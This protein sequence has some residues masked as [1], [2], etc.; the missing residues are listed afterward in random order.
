MVFQ[1]DFFGRNYMKNE[2]LP[3][4]KVGKINILLVDDRKENLLALAAILEAP[5]VNII[6]AE[7][8]NAA[9]GRMLEYDFAV[10]I[11]DVMMPEMNGF[12]VAE[13]MQ[14]NKKTMNT[15][16][17]FVTASRTS[18]QWD[19]IDRGYEVGAVDYLFKPL[20]PAI[21]K[22]KVGVFLKMYRSRMEVERLII[23][24]DRKNKELRELAAK[25]SHTGLLNHQS[26]HDML[27]LEFARM[28][29]ITSLD[30]SLL[31]LDLDHFKDVN[32]T[33][34]HAYGDFVLQRFAGLLK[35]TV[36]ETDIVARYGGEEFAALLP[37]TD[38]DGARVL[39]EKIRGKV[40]WSDFDNEGL[41]W[42]VTVSIGV[43]SYQ[44][45]SPTTAS[46][47]VKFADLALYCA[48][49]GGRNQVRVYR[50]GEP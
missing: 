1:G 35:E 31:M 42:Q 33:H 41:F 48:K 26:F 16:I 37:H 14:K 6:T 43:A 22:K 20:N 21:M 9:L 4:K 27:N 11:L 50:G 18:K 30:F 32:D 29:R 34:G 40:E 12:E 2:Y 17:V 3:T 15:P 7:S 45:H 44:T 49:E 38:L 10:V 39:A 25:D 36:R 23:S 19:Y 24:I 46:D 5:D 47:L 28:K 8:G 13:L